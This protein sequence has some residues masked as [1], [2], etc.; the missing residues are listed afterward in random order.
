[1]DLWQQ[2]YLMS[3]LGNLPGVSN[4]TKPT[5]EVMANNFEK[6]EKN[7]SA[8]KIDLIAQTSLIC[9][10]YENPNQVNLLWCKVLLK[11]FPGNHG[12]HI[13]ECPAI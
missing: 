2:G 11:S 5:T 9:L 6:K 1:M 8:Q 4:C 10:T 13:N 3:R 12:V 7:M